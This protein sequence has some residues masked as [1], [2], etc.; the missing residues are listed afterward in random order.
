MRVCI[1]RGSSQ[2]GGSCVELEAEGFRLLL[3]L[4]LPLDAGDADPSL[5]PD[6]S[7]LRKND[8]TLLGIV[9]SHCHRDHWGLI[10]L[11]TS[12][13]P[14]FLSTATD[15][16]MRAASAFVPG[17]FAP[18]ASGHLADGKPLAIGPFTVTPYLVDHSGFDAY[19]LLVQAGGKTVFYSGDF[20]GH[21]RKGALFERFL[22]CPPSNVDLM[23]MEGSSLGRLANDEAFPTEAMLEE[24]F[25]KS[26]RNTS[27]LA[28][29]ACSAQNI[30]RVVTVYRAAKKSGRQLVVDA[31]AAEVLKATGI[32]SIPKPADNWTDVRV[33]IPQ[34]QRVML[35][36]A[37]IASIVESYKGRRVWPEEL[38]NLRSQIVMLVRPWM[39]QEIADRGALHDARVIWSQWN[40]YLLEGPG[41]IFKQDCNARGLPFEQIHTSGHA[42]PIDLRRM[43]DAVKPK[44]LMAI[45][46][47]RPDDYPKLFANVIGGQDGIWGEV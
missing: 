45:H 4:G 21:G 20:R 28:L 34:R 38:A 35:K 31:Y 46:T 6:I 29:V 36:N 11:V 33:F 39:I 24:Q 16:I 40:G 25:L 10:P 12:G 43:A 47:F 22:R 23:L 1:H 9:L 42:S 18:E 30:D 19:A 32:P 15:R 14:L 26:F 8:P 37:G 2:I 13:V 5:L 3:D 44:R 17:G 7:G 41:Q 27:G